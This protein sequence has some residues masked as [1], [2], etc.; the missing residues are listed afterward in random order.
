VGSFARVGLPLDVMTPSGRTLLLNFTYEP[1]GVIGWQRA[2]TMLCLGKVEVVRSYATALRAVSW[3]VPMPAVVK[4]HRFVRRH[5]VR[6]ALSRRNVFLRDDYRCQYCGL[7]FPA[8][9]LT[10]DHV[11]PRAQGGG[12]S[13]ENV[14]A[15][16]GPCNRR[17]GGRTPEQA[18]MAL[19][20]QPRR[21]GEIAP[22][23]A[24]GAGGVSL[25]EPWREFLAHY[26]S[27]AAKVAG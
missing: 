27:H 16:C 6:V 24:I 26:A 10:C 20:K 12:M 21:P 7:R 11:V 2:I 25:P 1:L 4:L 18:R 19:R 23:V 14:V 8:K 22:H 15:A 5:R 9:E 17:K 3:T 13:W